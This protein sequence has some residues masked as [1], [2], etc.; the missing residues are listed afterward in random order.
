MMTMMMIMIIS[1]TYD[2]K[3]AL[4]LDDDGG[5]WKIH[6]NLD[7]HDNRGVDVVYDDNDGYGDVKMWANI[8]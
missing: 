6:D 1:I 2:E 4:H 5:D 7:D 8:K 3:I